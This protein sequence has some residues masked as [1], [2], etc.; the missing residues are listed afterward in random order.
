MAKKKS[1]NS[2]KNF[3]KKRQKKVSK[4]SEMPKALYC[5]NYGQD[6]EAPL[7]PDICDPAE[8]ID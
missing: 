3:K 5:M 8:G 4:I 1:K 7:E 2:K 6:M